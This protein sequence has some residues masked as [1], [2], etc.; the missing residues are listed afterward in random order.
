[1]RYIENVLLKQAVLAEN[2]TAEPVLSF[3]VFL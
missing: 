1:M 3:F 2:S